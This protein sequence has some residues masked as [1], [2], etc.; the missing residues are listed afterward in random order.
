MNGL[1]NK[2]VYTFSCPD[3]V[4]IVIDEA[5]H[6]K[7]K[8]TYCFSVVVSMINALKKMK[9]SKLLLMS[10]TPFDKADK[11][12]PTLFY[13]LGYIP[14]ATV[15]QLNKYTVE[16]LINKIDIPALGKKLSYPN[17]PM[18]SMEIEES[19]YKNEKKAIY[20]LADEKLTKQIEL[21]NKEILNLRLNIKNCSKSAHILAKISNLMMKIELLKADILVELTEKYLKEGKHVVIFVKYLDTIKKLKLLLEK[22]PYS[23]IVGGQKAHDRDRNINDFNSGKTSLMISTLKCGCAGISLNDTIGGQERVSLIS[24]S[25]SLIDLLQAFGRTFRMNNKSDVLQLVIFV[26]SKDK[27]Y[28]IK[29]CDSIEYKM[30]NNLNS[31]MNDLSLFLNGSITT[32]YDIVK[33]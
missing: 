30:M 14:E 3:D 12:L 21:H 4:L 5:H 9:S 16:H 18:L 7:N 11:Q 31:K 15:S 27:D 22:Y 2:N 29:D 6:I 26:G 32:V 24:S 28:Q 1:Q 33:N 13:L 17:G 19:K 10:A 8:D 20:H 23:I 25:F